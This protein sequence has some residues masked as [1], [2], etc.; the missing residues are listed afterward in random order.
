MRG[1]V[2]VIDRIFVDGF[3]TSAPAGIVILG[4]AGPIR[5]GDT[6]RRLNNA[7]LNDAGCDRI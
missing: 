4:A 7:G 3:D 5:A 1:A 6:Q 2:T